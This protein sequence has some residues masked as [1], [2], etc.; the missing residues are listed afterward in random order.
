VPTVIRVV[1]ARPQRSSGLFDQDTAM[2]VVTANERLQCIRRDIS[3]DVVKVTRALA[4]L[5]PEPAGFLQL[6]DGWLASV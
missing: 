2:P 4:N 6:E 1:L 5:Q 3:L